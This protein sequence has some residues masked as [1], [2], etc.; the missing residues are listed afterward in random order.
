MN[1][2][3]YRRVL[4][5]SLLGIFVFFISPVEAAPPTRVLYTVTVAD[6]AQKTFHLSVTVEGV[7]EPKL[8]VAIPAW[9]PGWYVLT[10]ADKNIS[11][12]TAQNEAKATLPVEHP[13]RFTWQVTTNGAKNV[14][15]EYDLL[16]K[17]QDPEDVGTSTG[18]E[19]D[20]GFTAPYLDENNG[21]VPGPASL[22]YVIDGKASPCRIT[23]KVPTGW[24]IASANDPVE[25]DP[26]TFSAPNYDVL[27]DQPG[28]LGRFTRYDKTVQG[29]PFSVVLVGAEGK[30]AEK[31][32]NATWKIAEAGIRVFGSAPFP[33]YIFHLR[34]LEK[35]PA[36]MGLEHLNSTVISFP[37]TALEPA[38]LSA[39]TILAHEFT[40]AWNVKRI[41]SVA[42]GP[43]DYTK[44]VRVKDLWWLEGVTD[45]YAPR[46]IVEA[47]LA[48]EPYWFA[49][50]SDI[51]TAVQENPARKTV[52]LETA[53]LKAWEGRSEG[54]GGLSYYEKGL[55]VGMLLDAELRKRSQNR[56]GIDDLLKALMKEAI[57][58]GKGFP[59]GEIERL[60]SKLAGAD[61][62]P[63]FDRALR[64]TE[65]LDYDAILT[66]TGLQIDKTAQTVPDIGID[67][68]SLSFAN[69]GLRVGN[70]I[71]FGPAAKAGMKNNDIITAVEGKPID[72]LTGAVL[73]NKEAGDTLNVSVKRDNRLIRLTITLGGTKT[74]LYSL[75]PKK[76]PL[77][78]ESDLYHGMSGAH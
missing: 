73:G 35:S 25:G 64:S 71:A 21:F 76:N 40:H 38:E 1:C 44:E 15:L 5:A 11:H 53:S 31:F 24:K 72:E 78:S 19:K 7:T 46:L 2:F 66:G 60:A 32:V 16:A 45:Y 4:S 56:I 75:S 12:L 77:A 57:E 62:T 20:Y 18:I 28:E 42:L 63:F 55:L 61:L 69:G 14:T 41:R 43:F 54:F 6:T 33:R 58:T 3:L 68:K 49:Y 22:L 70:V 50:I 48:S 29:V 17:D 47:H 36:M 37:I 8:R 74:T 9:S 51:L 27:A 39:L 23:Y 10:N 13:D 52:T 59:E 34:F 67:T 30:N 65:E 26:T